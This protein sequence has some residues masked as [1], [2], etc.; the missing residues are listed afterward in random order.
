M[1]T[2]LAG[3]AATGA[4]VG[5]L[6]LGVEQLGHQVVGG[7]VRPAS[8]CSRRRRW[9]GSRPA[10]KS[11]GVG[12]RRRPRHAQAVR[13]SGRGSPPGPASGMPSSMPMVRI[14]IWA[15]RS[16][17]KSN[18]P[19]PTSGSRRAGAELADLRL[20]GGHLPGRED[21]REQ[22]AVQV[23]V[24]RVLEDDRP[25]RDLD[26]GLDQLEQRALRRSCRSASPSARPRRR[27]TG[28]ARRSRTSRCSRAASPRGAAA[29]PGTGR[30]RSRS[31]TGRSRAGVGVGDAHDA[32]HA[33]DLVSRYWSKP[34]MPFWRPTPLVLV[35][36]EGEIG[37]VG[38]AAVDAHGA[39]ADAAGDGHGP[40]GGVREHHAGQAVDA[41]VGD[42]HRV[43]VVIERDDTRAPARRSPPG[44]SS[45]SCRRRRRGS[46]RT[47][48]PLSNCSGRLPPRARVA[49]SSTPC[50]M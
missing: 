35:A 22:A 2:S 49:P 9:P 10:L 38:G 29:R 50:S 20:D 5:V 25:G 36:A 42:A 44:R 40:L 4:A 12:H 33:I 30:C 45:S 3:E 11:V 8:R 23:V 47:K 37:P 6:E 21:P 31:R 46:A 26:V 16:A 34:A 18:P 28:S 14:G 19:A 13:R 17:M 32:G 48:K 43:V 27:R 7:V 15:P 1:R 41:V 24:G 39:G